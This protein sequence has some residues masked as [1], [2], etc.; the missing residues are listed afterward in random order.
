MAEVTSSN[1]NQS[2]RLRLSTSCLSERTSSPAV[3]KASLSFP[4]LCSP[5]LSLVSSLMFLPSGNLNSKLLSTLESPSSPLQ[6]QPTCLRNV[7]LF[8][9]R[10]KMIHS[11]R[12]RSSVL[13]DR[14]CWTFF[15]LLDKDPGELG[16]DVEHHDGEDEADG[17][18]EDD[19]WV[20]AHAPQH[21][22]S[23]ILLKKRERENGIAW[24]RRRLTQRGPWSRPCRASSWCSS[25][26]QRRRT[27]CCLVGWRPAARPLC[28]GRSSSGC[29]R[30]PR[31]RR[32]S[33]APGYRTTESERRCRD[34]VSRYR[35]KVYTLRR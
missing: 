15:L 28:A 13:R 8:C 35:R 23:S 27:W 26:L 2:R 12:A 6:P 11:R 24:L 17:E 7:S 3:V 14:T 32:H 10:L 19:N 34:M 22:S 5:Y 29:A 4:L 33:G 16:S 20:T 31:A 30:R 9:D 18:D 25:C 1:T 21:V